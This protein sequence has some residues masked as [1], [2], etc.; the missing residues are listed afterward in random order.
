MSRTVS[1]TSILRGK[2][3]T[4]AGRLASMTRHEAAVLI[5]EHGG[6]FIPFVATRSAVVIVG[7]EGW[8]LAKDGRLT[9]KLRQARR[10]ARLG[11]EVAIFPE[12]E[13]LEQLHLERRGRLHGRYTADELARI[14]GTST[15]KLRTWVRAGLISPVDRDGDVE[16]FDYCQAAGAKTLV[17][18]SRAGVSTAR[19]R[20]SLSQLEAWLGDADHPLAQLT[21]WERSGRLL[22]RLE[23]GSL[24]EPDGQMH[25]EF[26]E[27]PQLSAL[28]WRPRDI[29]AEDWFDRGCREEEAGNLPAAAAA[30]RE[31]LLAGGPSSETCFNLANVLYA[32]GQ[33][34]QAGERFRQA[35]ELDPT[36]CEAWNNLGTVLAETAQADEAVAAYRRA[37][38]LNPSCSDAHYNLADT[39]DA[40]GRRSEARQHWRA[41]LQ[42]DPYGQWA[43]HARTRLKAS[44]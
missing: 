20:Q 21:A 17:D 10:L 37:L 1:S 32:A 28:P 24:A 44:G 13:L 22:V 43:D 39:L 36:F 38:E 2:Q 5:E 12:E 3:V 15:D 42:Q 41:Y 11:H 7:Q 16:H 29:S 26:G 9:R 4:V 33:K 18:L 40:L 31:A 27:Q 25:F 35:V 19:L 6:T 23:N 30:Y 8:P 14:L 34:A